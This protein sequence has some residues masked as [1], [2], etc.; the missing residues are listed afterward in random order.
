M[1]PQPLI[2]VPSDRK[3]IGHHPFQAVGEKYLRALLDAQVGVPLMLPSLDPALDLRELLP[4]FDG[5]L[6]TGSPSNIEPHRYNGEPSYPG[7][8]HDPHRDG[9]TLALL[10]LAIELGIPVLA[11]C[12]GL[13]EVNVALGG[14]LWQKVHEAGP[15]AEHREDTT[16]PLDIQYAPSHAIKLT[17][18]GWLEQAAAGCPAP[19]MV[20]SL[21]GQGIRKL[22]PALQIEAMA[23]DGLIEAVRLPPEQGFL[24]AVQWHPEWKVRE[25]PFYLG[26]FEVFGRAVS[27]RASARSGS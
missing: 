1:R 4:Q 6:L 2:A 21:H 26:I 16:Q 8:L 22:A 12:R 19:I 5:I 20:N 3:Q 24:L 10:P 9:T 23:P 7:N 17:P 14:T 25:N 11:I 13:Q 15:Y 18:G 27:A